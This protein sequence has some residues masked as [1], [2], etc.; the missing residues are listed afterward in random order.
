MIDVSAG[1]CGSACRPNGW[2]AS[3]FQNFMFRCRCQSPIGSIRNSSTSANWDRFLESASAL[4]RSRPLITIPY[5]KNLPPFTQVI[6]EVGNR[7]SVLTDQAAQLV[8]LH[9]RTPLE[10]P[11]PS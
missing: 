4:R 7:E 6:G 9:H 8:S 11:E 1:A 2:L 5:S 3:V 10:Q